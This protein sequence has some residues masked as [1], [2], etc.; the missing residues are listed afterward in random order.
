V[1]ESDTSNSGN[2]YVND[3]M[4]VDTANFIMPTNLE[5]DAYIRSSDTTIGDSINKCSGIAQPVR[6]TCLKRYTS[7][8]LYWYRSKL[9]EEA[10]ETEIT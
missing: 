5:N 3:L 10:C 1:T 6:N 2:T 9:H 4:I 8:R 7:L